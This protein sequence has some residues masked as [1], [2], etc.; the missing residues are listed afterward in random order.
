[1]PSEPLIDIDAL[2]A[3]IPGDSPAGGPIPFAV[4][5][6]LEEARKEVNRDEFDSDDPMRP[7][8]DVKADWPAVTRL[9]QDTLTET[10]KDLLVAARLAEA[11]ARGRGFGG[12]RDGL[13]LMRRLVAECWD[14]LQPPVE[15]EEDLEVR[16]APFYWLDSEDRAARFPN[17]VRQVPI[18][19]GGGAHYSW[20]QWK[21]SQGG[22]GGVTTADIEKAVEAAAREECQVTVD[23]LTEAAQE[24]DGLTRELAGRMGQLAPA[25]TGLRQAVSDCR[26]LAQQI[27]K[28]K[29]PGPSEDGG[30]GDGDG[31]L[32]GDM[33][34]AGT[35]PESGGTFLGRQVASRAQVYQQLK[36]AAAMLQ[37][38]EPH[39]PIPYLINRAV[40]LGALPFPDLMRELIRDSDVLAGMNRELGI[41][42]P[43]E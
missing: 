29:G 41:K 31:T 6:K 26:T 4:R 3:S 33:A 9:A 22:K 40:E 5:E 8:A 21:Q 27:L 43:E 13:R 11:L 34:Q 14:R 37:T 1:M 16:A 42:A 32:A 7:E 30:D 20:W 35:V 15:S 38:L 25:L 2:L 18:I 17:S 24:L 12:L 28:K 39:S 19:V 36:Q 23:D 10:S